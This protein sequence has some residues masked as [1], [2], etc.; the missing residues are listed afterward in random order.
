MKLLITGSP[1]SGKS[2]I[3]SELIAGVSPRRGFVT[4]ELVKDQR[5]TGFVVEDMN[6]LS[7]VLAQ[8]QNPTS[9]QVGRFYVL[10]EVLG[11]FTRNLSHP[12]AGVLLYLDEIGQMQLCF[13]EFKLL[14]E[15]YLDAPNDFVATITSVYSDE[16][17]KHILNRDDAVFF[18][19]T[20][21]NR[22]EVKK[23]LRI[24]L[25]NKD[26]FNELPP[27]LQ[28]TVV[29]YANDYLK[30]N[31]FISFGKLFTNAIKYFLEARISTVGIDTYAVKG[32]TNEHIVHYTLK[33]DWSCDCPLSNG[34]MPYDESTDCSHVQAVR[35]FIASLQRL[36]HSPVI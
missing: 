32:D 21:V 30:E 22:N 34:S 33:R 4:K 20:D 16:F 1:K 8:T 35:L 31:S 36:Q 3:L 17:T 27:A 10:P 26:L 14:V 13:N 25:D 11:Q 5:R 24:A 9:L 19:L 15:E 7:A 2:T 28:N 29:G 12:E 6:G 18:H 23:S